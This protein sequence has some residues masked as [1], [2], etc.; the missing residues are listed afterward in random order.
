MISELQWWVIIAVAIL[1][2]GAVLVVTLRRGGKLSFQDASIYIPDRMRRDDPM[3]AARLQCL[4]ERLP[5]IRAKK[6]E[7]FR[8]M[9]R[10]KGVSEEF[11]SGHEDFKVYALCVNILLYSM[12]G[13]RSVQ[14]VMQRELVEERF[15]RKRREDEWHTYVE[16]LVER[17]V[18]VID[19]NLDRDYDS[20]VNTAD[21]TPRTRIV[22]R[23]MLWWWDH[24]PENIMELRRIVED[25]LLAAREAG[26]KER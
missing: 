4:E 22:T 18:G 23:E 11:L 8:Q 24:D 25:V 3:L 19:R 9:L 21:G 1:G 10:E 6:L 26:C 5:V 20:Q 16:D 13:L 17:I 15:S 12:N 2:V 14:A 7:G